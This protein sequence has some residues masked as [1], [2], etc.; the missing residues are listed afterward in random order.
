MV[1]RSL[2]HL[3]LFKSTEAK[4]AAH[5]ISRRVR[6]GHFHKFEVRMDYVLSFRLA[7]AISK[8]KHING[9]QRWL[10]EK[11]TCYVDIRN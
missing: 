6:S 2:A 1:P 3:M 7:G 5:S 8:N 10:G 9:L 4:H 11:S